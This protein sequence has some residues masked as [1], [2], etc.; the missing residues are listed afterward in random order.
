MS[1]RVMVVG[2]D[3]T[4]GRAI[5]G[6]CCASEYVGSPLAWSPDG[7]SL[8]VIDAGNVRTVAVDGSWL[9]TLPAASVPT[10]SPDGRRLAFIDHRAALVGGQLA[11]EV[12]VATADGSG[13]RIVLPLPPPLAAMAVSWN[14]AVDRLAVLVSVRVALPPGG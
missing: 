12:G 2:V 9:A 13:R 4:A 10:W 5:T 8:A 3:G 1:D 11:M 6:V 14:R 7:R